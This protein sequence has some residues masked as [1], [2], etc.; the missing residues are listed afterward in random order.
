MPAHSRRPALH[1]SDEVRDELTA[2]SRSRTASAA[3]IERAQ[4]M[5]DYAA[6]ATVADIT[7]RLD[8]NRPKVERCLDKALQFGPQAA[9]ADLPRSG[10]PPKITPEARTWVVELA[11]Q[12]PKDLGY[13]HE[14]WTTDLLAWHVR[15]HCQQAGHPSL[16]RLARGTVSKILNSRP[17]KPHKS[18]Y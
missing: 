12:K 1:L 14:L 6:G 10:K 5:L 4:I 15:Q 17:V 8:T 18:T 16:C 2:L 7:R 13:P 11:C 3:H 9:L